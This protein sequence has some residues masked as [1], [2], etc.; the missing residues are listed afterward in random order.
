MGT[1]ATK[2]ETLTRFK[3]ESC[4]VVLDADE[5]L[6]LRECSKEDCGTIFA[7]EDRPCPDCGD[8]FTRRLGNGHEDCTEELVEIDENGNEVEDEEGEE[9]EDEEASDQQQ[10]ITKHPVLEE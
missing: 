4:E 3:C 1:K 8:N 7:S 5:V 10:S 9:V 2:T 6:P